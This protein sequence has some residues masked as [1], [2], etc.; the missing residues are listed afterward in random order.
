MQITLTPDVEDALTAQANK[1][2]T[3]PEILAL[4]M[5]RTHL[6][7]RQLSV[8]TSADMTL[9]EFLGDHIGS[10]SSSDYVP[11]GANLSE[12]TG[13]R[14]AAGLLKKYRQSQQ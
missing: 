10:L 3:T 8:E 1:L 7:K 4:E 13:T 14:F 11:G 9:A 6:K 5:L 12:N 2:G